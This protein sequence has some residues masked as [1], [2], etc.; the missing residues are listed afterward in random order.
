MRNALKLGFAMML[1][2]STATAGE[3]K[4]MDVSFT[5]GAVETSLT[6]VAG[7]PAKGRAVFA[8]RK[9]GNCLACHTNSEIPEEGFH[10]E[11]GPPMDGVADR[12]TEAELRGI[13]S[14]SKNMFE[15]TIMPAFYIDSGYERPLDDFAGQSI[16]TAQQVEDVVAYLMTLK[17]Q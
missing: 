6:G 11:V 5:D 16:L 12:W 9:E 13:V 10:G 4:P 14:N 1:C 2:A 8:N 7:D 15:G 17:E 3:L